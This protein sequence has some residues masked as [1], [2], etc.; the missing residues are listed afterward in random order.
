MFDFIRQYTYIVNIVASRIG[1]NWY[2]RL[3]TK[4]ADLE[5]KLEDVQTHNKVLLRKLKK[6][7][8]DRKKETR[9]PSKTYTYA[10]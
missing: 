3:Q 7:E 6:Y 10:A 2:I 4:I 9:T 8:P 1:I 5:H